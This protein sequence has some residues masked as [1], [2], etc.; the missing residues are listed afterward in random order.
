MTT[1]TNKRKPQ[2]A[3]RP[4]YDLT[5]FH[6]AV[7]A[8]L[9]EAGFDKLSKLHVMGQ[10]LHVGNDVAQLRAALVTEEA[11][12]LRD[13]LLFEDQKQVLKECI[14]LLYVVFGTLAT[15]DLPLSEPWAAVHENNMAKI[16]DGTVDTNGKLLKSRHHPKVD[17]SEFLR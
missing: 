17:L 8:K 2:F 12:E 3:F 6:K 5:E 16:K 11:R 10:P 9:T 14:D 13:A 4:I 7:H 1:T 15:Y